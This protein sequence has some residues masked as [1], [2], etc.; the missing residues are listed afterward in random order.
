MSGQDKN[1]KYFAR[2]LRQKDNDAEAILWSE[3]RNR[4]L[5][6]YKFVREF[7]IENYFADFACRRKKLVVEIDGSQHADRMHDNKR[8][9]WLNEQGWNVLRFT[10]MLV[11]KQKA[12]VLNTIV[13]VLEKRLRQKE[14]SIE[15]RFW[16]ATRIRL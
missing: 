4:R 12:V 14:E 16:P 7:P 1:P 3:L 8:D 15:W 13:E 5:H 9:T 10:N 11:L 2:Q 6:N